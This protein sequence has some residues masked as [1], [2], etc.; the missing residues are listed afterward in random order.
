MASRSHREWAI[1]GVLGI[2]GLAVCVALS[3]RVTRRAWA[4]IDAA[5]ST[6]PPR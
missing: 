6:A 3:I 2:L 4:A 5:K 1:D